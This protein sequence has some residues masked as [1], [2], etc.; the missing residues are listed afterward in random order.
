MPPMLPLSAP[1]IVPF[2]H[3]SVAAGVDPL[4][5]VLLLLVPVPSV[6]ELL[7]E[8]VLLLVLEPA[9]SSSL[10]AAKRT[11]GETM[12]KRAMRMALEDATTSSIRIVQMDYS[13]WVETGFSGVVERI[14]AAAVEPT[15]WPEALHALARSVDGTACGIRIESFETPS[16][17]QTWVGLEPDFERAY[18]DRYWSDDIWAE[19]AKRNAVGLAR[20]SDAL[21]TPTVRRKNAFINELCVP[22]ELDDLVG[23]L[24]T[25]DSRSMISFAAMKPRGRRP[26]DTRHAVIMEGL[27]PHIRRALLVDESLRAARTNE[28]TAWAAVDRLPVGAFVLDARR[29][30]LHANAAGARML[31]EGLVLDSRPIRELIATREPRL[32]TTTAGKSLAAVVIPLTAE[33]ALF[34]LAGERGRVLIIVTDPSAR[35]LPPG[36]LL[37]RLYGLTAAESRVALLV[38][39]GLAPKEA[40]DELGTAWNTVRAQLRQIYA[41]TQTSGQSAL[42]SLL[43]MLGLAR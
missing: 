39:R 10:Q 35:E 11:R 31:T 34:A 22:Y 29:R 40:A 19:E 43:V 3:V 14:Y 17:A 30:L 21:I 38:G 1:S 41:K 9:G 42:V 23:G 5:L 26:F 13:P 37:S 8:L 16:V 7:V 20:A 32:V 18:V 6:P 24:V 25:L 27:I 2:V 15:R 4:L 12:R 36:E 33:E 28:R